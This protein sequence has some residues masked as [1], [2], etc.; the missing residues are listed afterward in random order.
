MAQ[1]PPYVIFNSYSD[2]QA[3]HQ[4]PGPAL[5]GSDLNTEFLRIKATLDAINN[6]LALIQRSDGVLSNQSV[7]P[8][9]ITSSLAILIAGW[10]I[11]GPW[12]TATAYALKDYVTQAGNGYVCIV[13]HT[14]GVFATD[15]A[16]A[17]WALVS[18][19]GATGPQGLTGLT[20]PT[21]P[22][23]PVAPTF[24][25]RIINGDFRVDQRNSGTQLSLD[26]GTLKYT[27]DRWYA[28]STDTVIFT[29]GMSI[30]RVVGTGAN[31][32]AA[33]F[34]GSSASNTS[35]TF[36]QRI[37]SENC[38]DLL[39]QNVVVS[40]MISS[41]TL[42]IVTWT[43]YRPN[44]Q[45][46]WAGRTQIATGTIGINSTPA[47]YNFTFNAGGGVTSGL[48]IEF[49]TG[50]LAQLATLQYENVQLELG[51][52]PTAFERRHLGTELTLCQRHFCKS[53]DT[54]TRI[55][56]A[57]RVG[58]V[59][60]TLHFS[61]GSLITALYVPFPVEMFKAPT[62]TT[63][64]GAG[65]LSKTSWTPNAGGS[66]TDGTAGNTTTGINSRGFL[67]NP[68]STAANFYHHFAADAEL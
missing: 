42:T 20:G 7:S 23:G 40:A 51:T 66:F 48:S 1:P 26:S 27:L 46:N 62:I 16:A 39:N 5:L 34:Q 67:S 4:L 45:D 24:R 55:G 37:A 59:G 58:M 25:N 41:S 10:A 19:I 64:D 22:A 28:N 6:N 12:V 49:T 61:A 65:T 68:T 13:A 17:K 38:Y 14:A 50:Q 2:Y 32:N 21:G 9:T 11:K 30:T 15:L 36:G 18:T 35:T 54:G 47:N 33:R 53:Y 60:P 43:A 29:A 3:S 56:A 63:W 8:D 31:Q 57:T 52:Q 44:S